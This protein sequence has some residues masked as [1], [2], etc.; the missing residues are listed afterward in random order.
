MPLVG[1]YAAPDGYIYPC[2]VSNHALEERLVSEQG[3]SFTE[4]FNTEKIKRLRRLLSKGHWP[5]NCKTCQIA[6]EAGRESQ[7][8]RFNYGLLPQHAQAL[9][10]VGSDG[11]TD[12]P[13]KSLDVRWNNTCNFRCRMCNPKFSSAWQRDY[14]ALN[15]DYEISYDWSHLTEDSEFLSV[16]SEVVEISFAGG[17]PLITEAHYK[18]LEKLIELGVADNVA[19][20]YT[21]NL[22][23]LKFKGYDI[24]EL[25]AH[26]KAVNVTFSLD[27]FGKAVEYSREG[28]SKERFLANLEVL[29]TLPGITIS[30]HCVSS[31]FSI[32]S[33]PEYVSFCHRYDIKFSIT[34]LNYPLHYSSRVLSDCLKY[35]IRKQYEAQHKTGKFDYEFIL[36]DMEQKIE[37]IAELR[38]HFKEE[39]QKLDAIR[40]RSFCDYFPLYSAWFSSL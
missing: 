22:S 19:L 38:Q 31:I 7:R 33:I 8:H 21:T 39:T 28:F 2:C 10:T 23:V 17:E 25:W 9:E 6:E 13:I 11:S 32:L 34:C 35:T 37:N 24:V 14:D 40:K 1:V 3:G 18:M 30:S 20:K 26:F 12:Y 16:L 36:Y 29:R 27:G 15:L 5:K 4:A